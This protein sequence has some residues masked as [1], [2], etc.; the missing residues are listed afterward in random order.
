MGDHLP[1]P[2]P[3]HARSRNSDRA[4]GIHF[5]ADA[6]CA[7][8]DREAVKTRVDRTDHAERRI[9]EHRERLRRDLPDLVIDDRD[10]SIRLFSIGRGRVRTEQRVRSAG[11]IVCGVTR[12]LRIVYSSAAREPA[13]GW[14]GNDRRE[15]AVHDVV[16]C[17]E[18]LQDRCVS[19]DDR[20]VRIFRTGWIDSVVI[21][22]GLSAGSLRLRSEC[23]ILLRYL[24]AIPLCTGWLNVERAEEAAAELAAYG[25]TFRV[26]HRVEKESAFVLH[27]ER[28]S[29]GIRG[30]RRGYGRRRNVSE[31]RIVPAHQ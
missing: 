18:H 19:R 11:A 20:S 27:E 15:I 29:S 3:A 31:T 5:R 24:A 16:V 2:A 6:A 12:R 1:R 30:R 28:V 21:E 22:D 9:A 17:I 25:I 13:R 26:A 10:L 23:E 4:A 7:V 8:V 14:T